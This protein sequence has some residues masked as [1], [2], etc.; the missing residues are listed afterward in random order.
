MYHLN[1][2]EC[3]DSI[4]TYASLRCSTGSGTRYQALRPD[5][6]VDTHGLDDGGYNV[7]YMAPDE[8]MRF[9]VDVTE[10]GACRTEK[11]SLFSTPSVVA[12][13]IHKACPLHLYS[14]Q[15]YPHYV[16]LTSLVTGHFPL[17]EWI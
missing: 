5:E 12:C 10:N 4:L 7:G 14:L 15:F 1:K 8:Y 9:P 13:A 6:G 16:N 2:P 11:D 17:H 3:A